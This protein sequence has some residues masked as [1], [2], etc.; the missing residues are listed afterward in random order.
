MNDLKNFE[1]K[2]GYTFKNKNLLKEALTHSS[3]SVDSFCY[4]RLEFLGDSVLGMVVAKHL[5]ET[6]ATHSEGDLTKLRAAL[7]CEPALYKYAVKIDLGRELHLGKG[8][9]ASGGRGRKSILADAFEA[10]IAAIYLDSGL[11]A[12][13]EFVIPFLPDKKTLKSGKL[14][15]G[16]YKTALQEIVQQN[17]E[18]RISYELVGE[19][20]LAHSKT[21]TANV[22][23]NKKIEGTGSGRSK[24]EAEQQAALA[25]LK[26]MGY[27]KD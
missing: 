26:K 13:T 21:F 22:L 6:L 12:A 25:A 18:N 1:K 20:G 17:P 14:F 8:E 7:V 16:D 3:Y 24:K 15:S 19:E 9:E 11:A 4:E 5:Y 10:V 2:I 27:E 23:I